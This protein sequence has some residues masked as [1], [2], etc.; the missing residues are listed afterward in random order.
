MNR[1]RRD[2]VI[3]L[4]SEATVVHDRGQS[5]VSQRSV[6]G[7]PKQMLA[8][9]CAALRDDPD[10]LVLH[11]LR[12]RALMRLAL[13][14]AAAGHLVV[15]GLSARTAAETVGRVLD[16][17][18]IAERRGAERALAGNLRGVV[19]Q[20]SLRRRGGGREFARDVL[21]NTRAVSALIAQGQLAE[22][23]FAIDQGGFAG[24]QSLNERLVELVQN[25]AVDLQEAYRQAG[26]R[27][28]FLALLKRRGVDASALESST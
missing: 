26:D 28:A 10:V 5:I 9:A 1:V 8:A 27:E 15:G 7:G 21:F 19:A 3:T 23:P 12:S 2:H 6:R 4:E 11:D 24:M 22:L 18:P 20:V 17:Y 13:R 25:A 14:A 16:A